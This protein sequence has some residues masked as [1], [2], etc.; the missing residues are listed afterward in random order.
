MDKDPS[1]DDDPYANFPGTT[2]DAAKVVK[3]CLKEFADC[4]EFLER[5]FCLFFPQFI[6]PDC[7]SSQS[8]STNIWTQKYTKPLRCRIFFFYYSQVDIKNDK[9]HKELRE[10]LSR[11]NENG[12]MPNTL[13]SSTVETP[14]VL[15]PKT[16]IYAF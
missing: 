2:T 12:L 14:I 1:P 10:Y 7:K 3:G 13:S 8:Y 4:T 5:Y 9:R 15:S 6:S 16:G 11:T